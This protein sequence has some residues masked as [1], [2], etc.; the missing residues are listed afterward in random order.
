MKQD[1]RIAA[2]EFG[3]VQALDE[4]FARLDWKVSPIKDK[5]MYNQWYV[6]EC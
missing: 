1:A 5:V 2:A 6:I 3:Q 4:L